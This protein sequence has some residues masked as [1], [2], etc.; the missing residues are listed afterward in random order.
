MDNTLGNLDFIESKGH[1][2]CIRFS[3]PL[4]VTLD[5]GFL[6]THNLYQT[7]QDCKYIIVHQLMFEKKMAPFYKGLPE[8]DSSWSNKKLAQVVRQHL[9]IPFK[10]TIYLSTRKFPGGFYLKYLSDVLK[11]NKH[12][13]FQP[14][15]FRFRSI[16][17]LFH[18]FFS[19]LY[20]LFTPPLEVSLYRNSKEC[21]I[22]FL[23]YP[24]LN[25]TR[26]C[27]KPI[28]SECFVQIKQTDS[29]SPCS[30]N[31][32]LENTPLYKGSIN[33]PFCLEKDFGIVYLSSTQEHITK[34]SIISSIINKKKV[35][36]ICQ[37]YSSTHPY[38]VTSN[39]IRADW[40]SQ[41][42]DTQ[43]K[44][45]DREENEIFLDTLTFSD[46][47]CQTSNL[48]E[49]NTCEQTILQTSKNILY[50]DVVRLNL[51]NTTYLDYVTAIRKKDLT[52]NESLNRPI[53]TL[54]DGTTL[55][56]ADLAKDKRILDFT[57]M[58]N[59]S[60]KVE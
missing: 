13:S 1:Q 42:I 56:L 4:N 43:Q 41:F 30:L 45:S 7:P 51:K 37:K 40:F 35:H 39:M 28:C 31:T 22:C 59:L 44:E 17:S 26:C 6:T 29:H 11:S 9:A 16:I 60:E 49:N 34:S 38:V 57:I 12:K 21:L 15:T 8:F 46:I 53:I 48:P 54:Y 20:K 58:P 55:S 33:C 18:H 5:G 27:N 2:S 52:L 32:D 25:Y 3:I 23:Y 14:Y 19:T 24:K 47:G 50:T 10:N 36:D